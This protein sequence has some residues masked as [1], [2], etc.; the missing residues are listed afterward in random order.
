MNINKFLK[1]QFERLF[2]L[3]H[4]IRNIQP[5][6]F[7]WLNRG[8]RKFWKQFQ[9]KNISEAQMKIAESLKKDG[10][11]I[12]NIADFFPPEAGKSDISFFE[13]LKKYTLEKLNDPAIQSEI[14]SK[15]EMRPGK[16]GEKIFFTY[17]LGGDKNLISRDFENP[18]LKFVLRDKIISTAALYLKLA[19][20]F[21]SFYLMSTM[22]VPPDSPE[23]LSQRWHRDPEDKKLI[24][25][26]LYLNDVDEGTGPFSYIKGTHFGG[27]W[28]HLFPQR[29][30]AG[31]YPPNGELEKIIPKEDIKIC[32]GR[33]GTLIFCDTS[34][35]HKGGFSTE[36]SR[37]MSMASFVSRAS[38]FPINYERPGK[39]YLYE[40]SP[41]ARYAL[42][43]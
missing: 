20:K 43:K 21:N 3:Y 10:I 37:L 2:F 19:P 7:Y 25:V 4:R 27:R 31:S 9:P 23:Y 22:V 24:K 38:K 5:I 16:K 17:L 8:P 12:A 11:A 13:D 35:L 14:I 30:P 18:F 36:K 34:G 40:L 39:N 26:F 29:L 6:W 28:R 42:T 41:L 15:K 1:I 33:S 32:T